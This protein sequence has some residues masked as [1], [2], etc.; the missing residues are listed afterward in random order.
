MD[1][2]SKEA[3]GMGISEIAELLHVSHSTLR[4]YEEEG[5]DKA[6]AVG[7]FG[8]SQV[9]AF[10]PDRADRCYPVPQPGHSR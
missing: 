5:A 2:E 7:R 3:S 4:Y 8:V 10:I 9:L 1:D 6:H